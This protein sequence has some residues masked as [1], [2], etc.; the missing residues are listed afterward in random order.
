MKKGLKITNLEFEAYQDAGNK[1]LSDTDM[2]WDFE[3]ETW[4]RPGVEWETWYGGHW[5]YYENEEA[6][7]NALNEYQDEMDAWVLAYRV[8]QEEK[9]LAKIAKQE[10][11]R[12][13]KTLGGQFPILS[14]LKAA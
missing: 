2:A 5:S 7:E 11:Y 1:V 3:T 14:T 4:S 6:R 13:L 8:K 9:R 12:N 10:Y